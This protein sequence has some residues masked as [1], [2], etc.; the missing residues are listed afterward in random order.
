VVERAGPG[1]LAIVPRPRGNDWLDDEL[2]A[3]RAAGVAVLVSML[4]EDE[5]RELELSDE[6]AAAVRAGL[7]F[8]AM[9]VEDRTVPLDVAAARA[10]FAALAGQL[11]AGRTVAV[12]CRQSIGRASLVAAAVLVAEGVAPDEAWARVARARGRP[13]PDTEA[14]RA[15]VAAL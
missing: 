8:V 10:V 12:H 7:H 1:R 2:A 6:P 4:T 5:Q 11:A 14:Q 13:V 9:P 3:L 15:W